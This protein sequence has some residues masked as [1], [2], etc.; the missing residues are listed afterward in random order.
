MRGARAAQIDVQIGKDT[1][2]INVLG[3]LRATPKGT[4]ISVPLRQSVPSRARS[5][6]PPL[7]PFWLR[8]SAVSSAA[9]RVTNPNVGKAASG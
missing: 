9:G 2:A 8:I 3:P 7:L 5:Q 6:S 4:V 1:E